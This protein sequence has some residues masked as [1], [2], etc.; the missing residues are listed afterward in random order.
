[1]L[2]L[3]CPYRRTCCSNILGI[4]QPNSHT[5]HV[6]APQELIFNKSKRHTVRIVT[7]AIL[8]AIYDLPHHIANGCLNVLSASPPLPSSINLPL[9]PNVAID[10][11]AHTHQ[12][13]PPRWSS[14]LEFLLFSIGAR[15]WLSTVYQ[16]LPKYV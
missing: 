10:T 2:Y 3:F 14:L 13:C 1:M 15:S 5:Y 16:S 7:R 9:L 4:S 8:Q 12:S 6:T 11:H